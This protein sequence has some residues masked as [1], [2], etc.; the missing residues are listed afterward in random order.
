[1]ICER[2]VK[3]NHIA[4]CDLIFFRIRIHVPVK[5]HTHYHTIVKHVPVKHEYEEVH[6]PYKYHHRPHHH[7]RLADDDDD[8]DIVWSHKPFTKKKKFRHPFIKK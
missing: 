6:K 1:M 4:N 3:R 8:D 5:H 2:S 7:H